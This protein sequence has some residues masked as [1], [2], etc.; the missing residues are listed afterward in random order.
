MSDPV[1]RNQPERER[2]VILVED[3]LAGWSDYESVPGLR[4]FMHTAVND[5]F[6][7]RGL[8]GEL[9][10]AALDATRSEGLLVEPYCPYVRGFIEKHPEYL[11]LVPADRLDEFGLSAA[12]PGS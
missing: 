12:A 5:R 8:A 10:R 6:Q 11:D 7:G 2:F 3:E 1:V 4:S 9:I